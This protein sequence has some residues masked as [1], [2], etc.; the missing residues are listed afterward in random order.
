[1]SNKE[2]PQP[3]PKE[4]YVQRAQQTLAQ[5]QL[6]REQ[7]LTTDQRND[8]SFLEELKK[9]TGVFYDARSNPAVNEFISSVSQVATGT[10]QHTLASQIDSHNTRLDPDQRA[11]RFLIAAPFIP[12]TRFLQM[13][14]ATVLTLTD[15]DTRTVDVSDPTRP[16]E[17]RE[18]P[19][20]DSLRT[21]AS[22]RI[23]TTDAY[24]LL[25]LPQD[26]IPT[27]LNLFPRG[28]EE[29]DEH[30]KSYGQTDISYTFTFH[31]PTDIGREPREEDHIIYTSVTIKRLP[32]EE[33]LAQPMPPDAIILP[34]ERRARD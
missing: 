30:R 14:E 29:N 19:Y 24:T 23:H 7:L 25:E 1:M 16:K 8:P 27:F 11:L 21:A 4:F 20:L 26:N 12:S 28:V 10:F 22:T 15:G 2:L 13:V 33:P 6:R 3:Q 17:E 5:H 34:F 18:N 31:G 9:L 32:Q